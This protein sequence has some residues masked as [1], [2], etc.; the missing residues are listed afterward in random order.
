MSGSFDILDPRWTPGEN[1]AHCQPDRCAPARHHATPG[2]THRTLGWQD[3]GFCFRVTAGGVRTWTYRYRP[4][5]GAAYRRA[6]LGHYPALSLADARVAAEQ[7]R[8]QVRT[9]ADPQQDRRDD[10]EAQRAAQ[11]FDALCDLYLDHARRHKSSWKNDEGYLRANARPLWGERAAATITRP[12]V[13][14]LLLDVVGRS[15]TSANR[16]RSIL[17][18][19]FTW[20]VDN[21]LLDVSPMVGIKK[22][23]KEGQGKTR[24]LRDDELRVFWTAL[25][26]AGLTPPIS[27][28]LRIILLLGQRPAEVAGMTRDELI[29]FDAPDAALWALP[30]DRMKARRP[31]VV[32]L[33]ALAR[34]IIQGELTRQREA[35]GVEVEFV[36]A[37][38][39]AD[40]E[41]LARHSLSQAMRRVIAGLVADGANRDAV[42][43]LKADPPTPH[44]LRRTV[45]TGLSRLGIPR[46]D[47]QA[48]LAH[49]FSDIHG[50]YDRYDRL[51]EKRVALEAWER[52]VL[53]VLGDERRPDAKIVPLW[54]KR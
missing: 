48:V 13:A 5:S 11:T 36:F 52:H 3:S 35:A 32:P 21:S 46:E 44:D 34:A 17:V 26:D 12:D 18:T 54:A 49:T 22:P 9:G 14:K 37:S 47:R 40:R 20:A 31:H 24:T 1:L 7:N 2:R 19:M 28:A 4:G 38:R 39:F 25:D 53:D 29:D 10:R 33:P 23:A 30:A 41:R 27:A 50:T 15:P 16:L 51:R 45:G 6:T 8:A 42:A 43:R